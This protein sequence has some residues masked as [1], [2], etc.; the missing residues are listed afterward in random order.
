M[1]MTQSPVPAQSPLHPENTRPDAGVALSVITVPSGKALMQ[2]GK[3][4]MPAGE[5]VTVP[6]PVAVTRSS[7]LN[8]TSHERLLVMT[9]VTSCRPPAQSPLQLPNSQSS[10]ATALRATDVPLRKAAA[11]DPT[12]PAVH[13][14]PSGVD[15]T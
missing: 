11:H 10:S 8:A 2:L 7:G 9:T 1:V 5:D 6:L 15:D 3:Q 12:F 13:L 14:I 4:L